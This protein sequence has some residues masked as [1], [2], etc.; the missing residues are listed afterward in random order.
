MKRQLETEAREVESRRERKGRIETRVVAEE[1]DERD[2]REAGKCYRS[3][4]GGRQIPQ[5]QALLSIV[6]LL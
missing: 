6:C 1:E 4:M 5:R 3:R 2:D